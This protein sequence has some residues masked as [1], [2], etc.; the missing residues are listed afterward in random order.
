[1]ESAK[2]SAYTTSNEEGVNRVLR[3]KGKYVFFMESTAIE[4]FTERNCSLKMVGP[5]LDSKDY[6]I[7]MPKSK[8][9][10]IS[11]STI[12]LMKYK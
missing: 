4:Y 6:G 7:A 3:S 10:V 9:S 8:L 5:Q 11:T 2:P 1:M 12:F